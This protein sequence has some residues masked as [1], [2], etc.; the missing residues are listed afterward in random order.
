MEGG[1][2]ATAAGKTKVHVVKDLLSV[3]LFEWVMAVLGEGNRGETNQAK[4]KL[5][6]AH[7]LPPTFPN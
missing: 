2:S 1:Q 6:L 3:F 4:T 5:E 7:S